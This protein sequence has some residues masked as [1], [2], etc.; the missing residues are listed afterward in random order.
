[1]QLVTQ[2][3]GTRAAPRDDQQAL[4]CYE[5]PHA[6]PCTN[7]ECSRTETMKSVTVTAPSSAS[8]SETGFPPHP[9]QTG[10]SPNSK[11]M[12]TKTTTAGL[13]RCHRPGVCSAPSNEASTIH[14]SAPPNVNRSDD[15]QTTS[16]AKSQCH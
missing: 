5:V 12:A 8:S 2:A 4:L 3:S 13:V 1:M 15:P 9:P 10:S 16:Q 6:H 11:Y 7:A 14:A